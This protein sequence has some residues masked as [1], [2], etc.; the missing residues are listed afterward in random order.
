MHHSFLTEAQKVEQMLPHADGGIIPGDVHRYPELLAL[1]QQHGSPVVAPECPMDGLPSVRSDPRGIARMG[2]DHL[3]DQGFRRMSFVGVSAFGYSSQ[4]ERHFRGAVE[5]A[6]YQYEPG[7]DADEA[8][9]PLQTRPQDDW[10]RW[11]RALPKPIGLLTAGADLGRITAAVCRDMGIYVPEEVAILGVD[12]DEIVCNLADPPLSTIDHGMEQIGY[13]CAKLLDHLMDGGEPPAEPLVV[14]PVGVIPRQSTDA[15]A[16]DDPDLREAIRFIR[17]NACDGITAGQV[18]EHVI[19]GR[20]KIEQG[21]RRELGRTIHE[22]ITRVKV[23]HAKRLLLQSKLR[24]HE[25][26]LRAGFSNPSR[27]NEAFHRIEQ[28]TPTTYRRRHGGG[29]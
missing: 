8:L 28:T 19:A 3:R 16:I 2:L 17:A 26:A 27:L 23:E 18:V 10:Q 7:Y 5:A 22:E 15:L 6:G 24:L 21:F 20:R 1:I 11:L 29:G 13:E 9:G 25:I 14:P 4:R 12:D